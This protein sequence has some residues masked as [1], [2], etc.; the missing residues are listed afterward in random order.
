MK[1]RVSATIDPSTWKMLDEVMK[2][3]NYRNYSHA[4]EDA[5]KLLWNKI[6]GKNEK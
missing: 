6:N 5:I 2:K 3:S 1:K 4:I